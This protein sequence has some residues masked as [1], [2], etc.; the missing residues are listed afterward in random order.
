MRLIKQIFAA[1][2]R[3]VKRGQHLAEIED[4]YRSDIHSLSVRITRVEKNIKSLAAI[5]KVTF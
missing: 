1:L 5:L 4:R 2:K 3:F